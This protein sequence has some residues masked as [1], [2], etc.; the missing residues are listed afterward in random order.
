MCW[1]EGHLYGCVCVISIVLSLC[2]H[3]CVADV[4]AVDVIVA[5][6]TSPILSFIHWTRSV[7]DTDAYEIF[8]SFELQNHN[9]LEIY[10]T[11]TLRTTCHVAHCCEQIQCTVS[12][13]EMI[14]DLFKKKT[15]CINMYAHK[16]MSMSWIFAIFINIK[17]HK[18]NENPVKIIHTLHI[19]MQEMPKV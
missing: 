7:D 5:P 9:E 4:A 3:N 8:Y 14:F 19:C 12:L 11:H 15:R 13:L 2:T 18:F 16:I 17:A 10:T 1:V 6:F